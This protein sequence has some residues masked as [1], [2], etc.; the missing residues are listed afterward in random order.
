[1]PDPTG[2]KLAYPVRS[3]GRDRVTGLMP[4]APTVSVEDSRQ[5]FKEKKEPEKV[6]EHFVA[7]YGVDLAFKCR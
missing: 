3:I 2:D 6:P 7:L 1:M 4:S 5:A